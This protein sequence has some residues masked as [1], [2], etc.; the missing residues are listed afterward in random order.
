MVA[1]G[2]RATRMFLTRAPK[3]GIETPFIRALGELLD[4]DIE[5]DE[6]VK[7]MVEY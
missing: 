7:R 1:E 3:L 4:G 2:V 5:A 6:A